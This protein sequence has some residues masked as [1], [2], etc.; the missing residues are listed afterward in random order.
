M[1]GYHIYITTNWSRSVLYIGVTNDLTRRILEH[2]EDAL[3]SKK[4]FA[5]K[6]GCF[7]LVYYESYQ[8]VMEAISR[9]KELKG[10]NRKKKEVLI[11]GFNPEWKFLS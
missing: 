8:T 1:C 9:E 2:K 5:G 11:T 6:Y 10:W 3:S 4:S 7:H